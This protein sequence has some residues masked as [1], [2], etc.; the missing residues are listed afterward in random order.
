M[1]QPD[2]SDGQENR[3]TIEPT[4]PTHDACYLLR[5]LRKAIRLQAPDGS[6]LRR[7][8]SDRRPPRPPH[9][10]RGTRWKYNH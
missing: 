10:W 7:R 3:P 2:Y 5:P 4:R 1:L 9:R 6:I 8:M